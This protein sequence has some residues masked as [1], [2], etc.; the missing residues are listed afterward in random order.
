MFSA[1]HTQ[2]HQVRRAGAEQRPCSRALFGAGERVEAMALAG[3]PR[4]GNRSPCG[5]EALC[6]LLGARFLG[7]RSC[8]HGLKGVR[9]L[10]R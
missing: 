10:P 1:V 6:C 2:R 5:P 9:P 7:P 8:P 4:S 3:A